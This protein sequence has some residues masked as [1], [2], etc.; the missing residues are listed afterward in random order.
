M[1]LSRKGWNNVLI[2]S[3]LLMIFFFNGLHKKLNSV[4]TKQDVQA[5]LPAQNFVLAL[6]FP[7]QKKGLMSQQQVADLISY[8]QSVELTLVERKTNEQTLTRIY[9]AALWL[10]GEQL[11]SLINFQKSEADA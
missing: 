10:A 4:P 6:A 7:E 3:M 11:L 8:W 5:V 9:V 1:Q 2:F